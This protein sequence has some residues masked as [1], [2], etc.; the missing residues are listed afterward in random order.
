MSRKIIAASIGYIDTSQSPQGQILYVATEGLVTNPGDTPANTW[1][2]GRLS[3]DISFNWKVAAPFTGTQPVAGLGALQLS[4]TDGGLDDAKSWQFRDG[5]V[6]IKMIDVPLAGPAS[7]QEWNAGTTIATAIVERSEFDGL[8]GLRLVLRDTASIL[9]RPIQESTFTVGEAPD[10][11][12][13]L[14]PYAFG[15]PLTVEPVLI[16]GTTWEYWA[17]DG[18]LVDVANIRDNGLEIPYAV[19]TNGFTL[20]VAPSGKITCDPV[21][22]GTATTKGIHTS[23]ESEGGAL[24]DADRR[25]RS[26][27]LLAD[28]P[29]V[30]DITGYGDYAKAASAGGKFYFELFVVNAVAANDTGAEFPA[31]G[32]DMAIGIGANTPSNPQRLDNADEYSCWINRTSAAPE[33]FALLTYEDTVQIDNITDPL[34]ETSPHNDTIGVMV[35]FNTMQIRFRLNGADVGSWLTITA[36]SPLDS[37]YPLVAVATATGT[38]NVAKMV[39]QDEEFVQ[40]I[41]AGYSSWGG[42]GYSTTLGFEEFITSI[43]DKVSGL[44]VD[45]TSQTAIDDLAYSYSYYLNDSK[46]AAQVLFEGC[47]SHT[48]WYYIDRAGSLVFGRLAAPAASGV[49][50]FTDAEIIDVQR[51]E[52]DYARGLSNRMGALRNWSPIILNSSDTTLDEEVRVTLA[53]PYQHEAK[54]TNTLA[55]GY[56]HAKGANILPSYFRVAAD[57]DTEIDRLI[58]LY[59]SE[60]KIYVVE[61]AFDLDQFI[62]MDLGDTVTVNLNRYAL[63]SVDF[64]NSGFSDG[65]S[66]GFDGVVSGGNYL[67]MGLDGN[68]ASNKITL[69]LWG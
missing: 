35:N 15:T 17:H 3:G 19:T 42:S 32:W 24:S 69:T 43:T 51:I 64:T 68:F 48:G 52:T 28:S 5:A 33:S 18:T 38:N 27:H 41:P 54:S 20:D 36:N 59:A 30:V 8:T 16:N 9:D 39:L 63:Q 1:F 49:T 14:K 67:L 65:F 47:A 46:T 34:G 55:S 61:A 22:S 44:S 45:A 29:H 60:R 62:L 7:T 37:F 23:V 50:E 6:T 56:N 26:Q 40:S 10:G 58:A 21:V 25:L 31:G 53:E 2:Q 66:T 11:E 4:N 13:K 57:A 12:H